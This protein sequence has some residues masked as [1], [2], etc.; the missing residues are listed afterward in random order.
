MNTQISLKVTLIILVFGLVI[1]PVARA[2]EGGEVASEPP[3]KTQEDFKAW[4]AETYPDVTENLERMWTIHE[5]YP[6]LTRSQIRYLVQNPEDAVTAHW[7][8]DKYPGLTSE[9]VKHMIDHPL[10]ARR[11]NRIHSEYPNLTKEQV[12]A[13]VKNP[14]RAIRVHRIHEQYPGLEPD[15]VRFLAD[16]PKAAREPS[17]KDKKESEQERESLAEQITELEEIY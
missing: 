7:I 2:E 17:Q 1:S 3:P 11:M 8:H 9:G 6:G 15:E 4:M 13:L 5:E 10:Q 12:S 14:E 16:Q